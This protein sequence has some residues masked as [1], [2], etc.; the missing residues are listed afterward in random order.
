MG[1]TEI[2]FVENLIAGEVRFLLGQSHSGI[3]S[4]SA[5]IDKV[6]QVYPKCCL[7]RREIEDLVIA[8]VARTRTALEIDESS[9]RSTR[10]PAFRVEAEDDGLPTESTAAPKL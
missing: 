2:S 1:T 6:L 8:Q 4:T 10:V 5:C 3:V 9:P 7:T